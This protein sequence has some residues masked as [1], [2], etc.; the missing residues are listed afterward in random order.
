VFDVVIAAGGYT[1]S[2]PLL[3]DIESAGVLQEGKVTVDAEYR[4]S[5]RKNAVAR[6]TGL[7][8]LGSLEQGELRDEEM[9]FAVERGARLL[10]SVVE[11]VGNGDENSRGEVAML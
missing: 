3:A 9:G 2:T 11:C 10:E 7:W 6:D 8:V 1:R 5:F 4:V